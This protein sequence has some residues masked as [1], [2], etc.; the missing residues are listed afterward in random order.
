MIIRI[1]N[2]AKVETASI[3]KQSISTNTLAYSKQYAK[4]KLLGF[5]FVK[6]KTKKKTEKSTKI[7]ALQLVKIF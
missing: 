2:D 7:L 5:F 1:K 4:K 3:L 6:L